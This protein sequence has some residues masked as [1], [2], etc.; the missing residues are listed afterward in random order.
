MINENFWEELWKIL[1]EIEDNTYW[2][3][4]FHLTEKD[5]IEIKKRL[6]KSIDK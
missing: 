2:S 1:L 6:I 5:F 3:S 4:N